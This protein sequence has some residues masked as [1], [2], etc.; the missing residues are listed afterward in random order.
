VTEGRYETVRLHVVILNFFLK[1]NLILEIKTEA[2]PCSTT[3]LIRYVNEQNCSA[4][5]K[6]RGWCEVERSFS[7]HALQAAVWKCSTYIQLSVF[8]CA[9][10]SCNDLSG[11]RS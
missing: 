8:A 2:C 1:Q 6:R 10:S 5:L 7:I 9:L 4:R 11:N 3:I